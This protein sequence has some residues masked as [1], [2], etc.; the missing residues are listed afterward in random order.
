LGKGGERKGSELGK[1]DRGGFKFHEGL[2][3]LG[4]EG[5]DRRARTNVKKTKR[6]QK[7]VTVKGKKK[8]NWLVIIE[9]TKR[10][11]RLTRTE[12]KGGPGAHMLCKEKKRSP[13]QR[14]LEVTKDY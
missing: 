5:R 10:K 1:T 14:R 6:R 3:G 2:G 11:G 9:H 12:L 13:N 7:S 8:Q 4:R